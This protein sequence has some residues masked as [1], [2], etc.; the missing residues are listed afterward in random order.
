MIYDMILSASD[1]SHDSVN[2]VHSYKLGYSALPM[3]RVGSSDDDAREKETQL[4][5]SSEREMAASSSDIRYELGNT[6]LGDST[7]EL[8]AAKTTLSKLLKISD[9]VIN[10]LLSADEL[11]AQI[12]SDIAE[13]LLKA[14]K[15]ICELLNKLQADTRHLIG[16]VICLDSTES[17]PLMY[18]L[19][20]RFFPSEEIA[21][22]FSC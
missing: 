17:I 16:E 12:L 7:A 10:L 14:L 9:D 5:N 18:K 21:I 4:T 20:D 2:S 22:F 8:K 19:H 3:A 11:E 1:K 6:R 13:Q 15:H